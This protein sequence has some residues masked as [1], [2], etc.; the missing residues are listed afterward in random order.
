MV[1]FFSH[2]NSVGK[3]IGEIDRKENKRCKRLIHILSD[4]HYLQRVLHLFLP[5]WIT[6]WWKSMYVLSWV[7]WN[8]KS[9]HFSILLLIQ[10]ICAWIRA[11]K[12]KPTFQKPLYIYQYD[13]YVQSDWCNTNM[14]SFCRGLALSKWTFSK[15]IV[16]STV[17]VCAW[18]FAY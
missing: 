17:R 5:L 16:W 8:A 14:K 4:C 15:I 3:R 18:Y 13:V 1:F 10:L 7:N 9:V 6:R 11:T 12:G 2:P